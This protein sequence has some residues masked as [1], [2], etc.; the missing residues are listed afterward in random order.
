MQKLGYMSEGQEF[1][2]AIADLL[3]PWWSTYNRFAKIWFLLESRVSP[4]LIPHPLHGATLPL[5]SS[6]ERM[7]QYLH[8][9]YVITSIGCFSRLSD[10]KIVACLAVSM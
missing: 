4:S 3:P 9:P 2:L 10:S 5:T 1:I 8:L 7:V 6:W